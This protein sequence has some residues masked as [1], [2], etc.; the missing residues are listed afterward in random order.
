VSF[1]L[2]SIAVI[3]KVKRLLA[4]LKGYLLAKRGKH[5]SREK[6]DK[7]QLK[8]FNNFKR[9]VL[10]QSSY[11]SAYLTDNLQQFPVINKA[12]HM[13]NFNTINTQKLLKEDALNIAIQS[14]HS[15]N[16]KPEYKG[17]SVGLSSG[18]SGNRGLFVVSEQEQAQWVGYIIGKMLPLSIKKHRVAFFLRANNNLYQ[19]ANG[20][21]VSFQFFDLINGISANIN[22]LNNFSPTLLIAPGSVLR[23]IAQ[24]PTHI[25]PSR[26][27]AVAEVLEHEDRQIIEQRFN[28]KVEQIYQCTE[29]FLAATCSAGNLHL[30]ED[31]CII[32]KQW[33]DKSTG[34]FSPIVTDLRRTTQPVVRYLLDDVLIED[35]TPCECGSAMTRIKNIEG[36]CDDVLKFKGIAGA[37]VDVFS[38][39][40]RN[41]IIS[42]SDKIEHYKLTQTDK[43]KV[44]I[45]IHPLTPKI[46]NNITQGLDDLW[47]RL[48]VIP[49]E[50]TFKA[51]PLK[52]GIEKQRRV[53]RLCNG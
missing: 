10:V 48:S 45:E 7:M 24:S 46:I 17:F 1:H 31:T 42:S 43:N 2:K 32:E 39:Y 27:I 49:P 21:M 6:I 44:L 23:R 5:L 34:R 8:A 26:V 15:R 4:F 16:F 9:N 47:R 41:T 28:I 51:I 40:I 29:G 22:E 18:T 13:S 36:R 38:D 30:N 50:Y 37:D 52:V 53:V 25:S 3:N 33:L 35:T 19:S 14:E 11:Y 20:L 12:I